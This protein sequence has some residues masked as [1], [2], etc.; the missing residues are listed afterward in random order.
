VSDRSRWEETNP[1]LGRQLKGTT[2]D[3]ELKTMSE[4]SF[5]RQRLCWWPDKSAEQLIDQA[6]WDKLATMSPIRQGKQAFAVRFSPD[7]ELVCVAAAI[8]SMSF[9]K[10]HI[11][12]VLHRSTHHGVQWLVEWLRDRWQKTALIVV[13]GK[14]GAQALVEKLKAAGVSKKAICEP[15]TADV[16]ASTSRLLDAVHEEAITHFDQPVLNAAALGAKKRAIGKDGGFGFG[17]I[18]GTDVTP[19]EACALAHWGAMTT[20]RDPRRRLRI[21]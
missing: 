2:I 20:K 16:I 11:E 9:D 1:S 13:D 8:N 15:R 18:E 19:I 10:P 4:D 3:A 14:A 6:S 5:A 12:V 21:G 7:G 17:G